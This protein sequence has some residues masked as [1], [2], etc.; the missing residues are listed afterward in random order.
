MHG[1]TL[2][3]CSTPES[4]ESECMQPN[5]SK[6]GYDLKEQLGTCRRRGVKQP[7]CQT[8]TIFDG[9]VARVEILWPVVEIPIF[10]NRRKWLIEDGEF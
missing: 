7:Q 9:E 6:N 1:K 3:D 8:C 5:M 2:R 4:I 10:P